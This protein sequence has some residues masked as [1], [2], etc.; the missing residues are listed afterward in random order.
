[1]CLPSCLLVEQ[2]KRCVGIDDLE[3][4]TNSRRKSWRT[5]SWVG[6]KTED[7]EILPG[8]HSHVFKCL[9]RAALPSQLGPTEAAEPNLNGVLYHSVQ[10]SGGTCDDNADAK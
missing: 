1:M 10:D 8:M 5:F 7:A 6:A 3:L 2:K 4:L 9:P